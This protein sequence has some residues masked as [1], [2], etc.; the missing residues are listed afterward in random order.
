MQKQGPKTLC[1]PATF[2]MKR[3]SSKGHSKQR[4][5][6]GKGTEE[7]C[8]QQIA[9]C[10]HHLEM[11]LKCPSLKRSEVFNNYRKWSKAIYILTSF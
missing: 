4:S 3:I 9:N 6:V 2:H 11:T 5:K 7:E 8:A 10:K 1:F